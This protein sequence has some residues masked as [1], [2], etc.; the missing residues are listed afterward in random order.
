MPGRLR[1]YAGSLEEGVC[2]VL[3]AALVTTTSLQ[4]FTRYV[5][6]APLPWTEEL[7]K[8]LFV[9]ITF[10]GSAVIAK[11][12]THISIDFVTTLLP[13]GARRWVLVAGQVI[14][15]TILLL[16][17]FKGVRLLEITGQ[18][19]SPALN[20]PW[21]YVYA[22]FPLGMFLMAARYVCRLPALLRGQARP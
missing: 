17:G 7:A 22:A 18:S 11:R 1:G 16:L 6:N 10:L 2:Y 5:I 13:A 19:E 14:T 21:V 4:V 20:V 8:M 15:V 3:L 12:G 9:W